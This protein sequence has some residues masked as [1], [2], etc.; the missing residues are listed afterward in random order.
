MKQPDEKEMKEIRGALENRNILIAWKPEY[1]YGILILDEQHRGIVAA[2][3]SL[4]YATQHKLGG[5]MLAPVVG[6][7]TEYARIHFGMEEEFLEKCGFPDIQ[8]HKELHRKLMSET[9][10]IGRKSIDRRDPQMFLQFLKEWWVGH[11]CHADLAFRQY[12]AANR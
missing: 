9:D 7:V 11:I 5:N 12:I 1:E 6:M 10:S 3:N 2:M 8:E 4:Y